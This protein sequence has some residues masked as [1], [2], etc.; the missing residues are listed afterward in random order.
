V[1]LPRIVAKH[2]AIQ[3]LTN[4]ANT[5]ICWANDLLS[6]ERE[7]LQGDVHNLV[8]VVQ[9]EQHITLSQAV[10]WVGERHNTEMR[11]FLE[12]EAT[13]PQM[14]IEMTTELN[15]YLGL[16][17]AMMRGSLDWA[18]MTARHSVAERAVGE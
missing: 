6:Y 3:Q 8:L 11:T 2:P 9:H 4:L 18:Y 13:L 5:V 17:R 12:I 1:K 16:L 15:H 10:A 7:R 14:G